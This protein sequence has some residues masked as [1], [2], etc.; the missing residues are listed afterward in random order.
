[1]GATNNLHKLFI[2]NPTRRLFFLIQTQS[3]YKSWHLK[4]T[5]TDEGETF[6]TLLIAYCL[7]LI[8]YCLLLMY[9]QLNIPIHTQH[10]P[11]CGTGTKWNENLN[12]SA[13][14]RRINGEA[15][16]W[17]RLGSRA[18]IHPFFFFFLFFNQAPTGVASSMDSISLLVL[19]MMPSFSY[20]HISGIILSKLDMLSTR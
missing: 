4:V 9:I 19:A 15:F 10:P 13:P 6:K 7:L 17:W 1:M 14:K 12:G 5:P 11:I 18:H 20:P 3:P 16:L 2:N 8:A